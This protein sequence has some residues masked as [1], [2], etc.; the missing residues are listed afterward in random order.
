MGVDWDRKDHPFRLVRDKPEIS[1]ISWNLDCETSLVGKALY[2]EE[3][4]VSIYIIYF[5]LMKRL[6]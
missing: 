6:Q 5:I 2:E 3:A 4:S 1:Q